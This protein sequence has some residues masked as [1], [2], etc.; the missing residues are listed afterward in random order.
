[1]RPSI[2]NAVYYGDIKRTV[3]NRQYVS[4][5]GILGRAWPVSAD[6][7]PFDE[8]SE[9]LEYCDRMLRVVGRYYFQPNIPDPSDENI[10]IVYEDSLT[11]L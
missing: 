8:C 4:L 9:A 10:Y 2:P 5:M 1:M 6:E 7:P 3:H 11:F